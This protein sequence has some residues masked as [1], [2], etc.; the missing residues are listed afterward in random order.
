MALHTHTQTLSSG[1]A[2]PPDRPGKRLLLQ[3]TA[4]PSGVLQQMGMRTHMQTLSSGMASTPVGS[5]KELLLQ[6]TAGMARTLQSCGKELLLQ[7]TAGASAF[8]HPLPRVRHPTL[9]EQLS[10]QALCQEMLL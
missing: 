10:V 1:I 3:R 6:S 9:L 7:S 4:R 2:R 5:G 8:R